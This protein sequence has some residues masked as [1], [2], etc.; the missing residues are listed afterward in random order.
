[1]AARTSS[2]T[3][4]LRIDGLRETLAAMN[5]MGPDAN[6]EIRAKSLELSRL[7]AERAKAA[8]RAQ[9]RQGPLVASTVKPKLDR[10]PTVTAGG[11]SPR[12]GRGRARP[13]ELLFGSEFGSHRF[14]QFGKPHRGRQGYWFFP[15]IEAEQQA[16]AQ[17]WF[18][19]ADE[20]VRRF[21]AGVR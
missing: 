3:V 12:L 14:K 1:M 21:S 11:S 5:R 15:V 18:A 17:A 19:A 8:G 4:T 9:G 2:L 16:V 13:F 20:V 7:L 6:R 10:V